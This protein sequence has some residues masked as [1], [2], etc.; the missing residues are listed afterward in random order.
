MLTSSGTG[1]VLFPVFHAEAAEAEA[2]SLVA[3]VRLAAEAAIFN[4]WMDEVILYLKLF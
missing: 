3:E 2:S 1:E 4:V